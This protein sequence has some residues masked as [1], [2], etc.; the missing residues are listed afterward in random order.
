[1]QMNKIKILIIGLVLLAA[2]PF[3][4]YGASSFYSVYYPE[5]IGDEWNQSD[6][7]IVKINS[8]GK[9]YQF[10]DIS[11]Y[12]AYI[13]NGPER[14]G[15]S[16]ESS[17]CWY[18]KSRLG[19]IKLFKVNPNA[20]VS[21]LFSKEIYVY[22]AEFDA[23]FNMVFDGVWNTT[24][25]VQTM[26]SNTAWIMCVFRSNN[27]DLSDAGGLN[28]IINVQDISGLDLKY[29]IFE[30]FTYTFNLN[31]GTYNNSTRSFT[32][33]RYGVESMTLASPVRTGYT[34]GGWKAGNNV[35]SGTLEK[36][37]DKVIFA[38]TT[39]TAIWNEV[40]GTSVKLNKEYAIFEENSGETLQL[41]ATVY[42]SDTYNK[43]IS[44]SSSNTAVA[45]VDS[46]GKVT[47]LAGGTAVITAKLDNGVYASCQIYVMDF[48]IKVPD[49]CQ[50]NNVYKISVNISNNGTS[51]MSGRKNVILDVDNNV[52]IIRIGDNA[53]RYNVLAES[54]AY[55][56]AFS[57]VGGTLVNT[58]DS[59]DI[60]FRVV[61][62]KEVE[63]A[64]DYEGSIS[65]SVK[66]V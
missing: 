39:F 13:T 22:C 38:D 29:I 66:V 20:K 47:A 28:T 54:S 10:S 25:D 50:V 61:P 23:N 30:P 26:R 16:I 40:E 32:R 21:F 24:G 31:G 1:M 17:F 56:G 41:T 48:D 63:K 44:W 2:A 58:S 51:G 60:Y 45:S 9:M 3:A 42:P 14:I 18:N 4:V 35:Y 34:F 59:V 27:G 15:N 19:Y 62:E 46:N 49:Y 33:S 65:F 11:S 52:E 37:Y 8:P 57:A 36:K 12:S 64:G 6:S 43:N 55:E 5:K 53:S 7:N